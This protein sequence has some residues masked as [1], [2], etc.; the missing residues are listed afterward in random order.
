MDASS[1]R[2]KLLVATPV[3]GDP[4]FNR[5]VV[6]VLEHSPDGAV[7]LVLNRPSDTAVVEPL[8]QWKALAAEPA[9]VF[10]GGP[11]S[12]D[13]VIGLGRRKAGASEAGWSPV[14]GSVGTLD[15]DDLDGALADVDAVR[16]F[17]GYAG[18]GAD[19]LEGE[20]AAR[21]WWVVDALPGDA[22]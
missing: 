16:L 8:P 12:R 11:V 7:G 6:L 15:L 17:A 2:G 14:V 5:T 19:Q 4:N 18:W 9:V 21:A 3:L 1:L 20:I 22:V 10:V 13:L